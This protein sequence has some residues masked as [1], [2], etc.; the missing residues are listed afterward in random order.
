M[1]WP[2]LNDWREIFTREN[3]QIIDLNLMWNK[4]TCLNASITQSKLPIMMQTQIRA[5][6]MGWGGATLKSLQPCLMPMPNIKL[7]ATVDSHTIMAKQKYDDQ[8]W[9]TGR[10]IL[11]KITNQQTT[12]T[13]CEINRPALMHQYHFPNMQLWCKHKSKQPIWDEEGRQQPIWD[14]E[15]RP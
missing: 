8:I 11:Q 2:N 7:F 12:W 1:W 3:N 13:W 5:T 6:N 14:E 15:G 10:K 9:T 4:P